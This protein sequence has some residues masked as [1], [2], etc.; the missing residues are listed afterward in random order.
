MASGLP[1]G[2]L[3]PRPGLKHILQLPNTSTE[4]A[5]NGVRLVPFSF[6]VDDSYMLCFTHNRMYIIK[7][8]VVQANINGSGNNYLTTTIGS[9]IVDDMCWT[10]SALCLIQRQ[11]QS[12]R[13][14]FSPA[15]LRYQL[16]T[17]KQT[18]RQSYANDRHHRTRSR[19]DDRDHKL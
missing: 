17:P 8:G 16:N 6:S 4:S 9:S 2:G 5:G 18:R 7:N 1:Q 14:T 3:R 10:Q 11:S 15:R 19:T 13:P 12:E